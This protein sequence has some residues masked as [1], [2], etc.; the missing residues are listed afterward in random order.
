MFVAALMA[1]GLSAFAQPGDPEQLL[2]A[3]ISAHQAG[4][5]D[6]AIAKYRE[7][8]KSVPDSIDVRSNLGAALARAGRYG[9]AIA[10][11]RK[12][13]DGRPA[14]SRIRLNLALAYY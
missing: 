14:D 6:T 9:E 11:Y 4:E 1:V 2:K 8:L 10:E 13:V 3:A 12:A 5:V 7:Y